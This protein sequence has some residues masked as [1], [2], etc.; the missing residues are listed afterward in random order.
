[1]TKNE[2]TEAMI[3]NLH[4]LLVGMQTDLKDRDQSGEFS[5]EFLRGFSECSWHVMEWLEL[6]VKES[7][8]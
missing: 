2:F 6:M 5:K 1:M 3:P 8:K 4:A 7:K